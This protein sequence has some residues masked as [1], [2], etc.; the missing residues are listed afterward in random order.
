[1]RRLLLLSALALAGCPNIPSPTRSEV[2]SLEVAIEGLYTSANGVRTPLPVVASCAAQFD[3][4]QAAV[5]L[6]VRG[7]ETCRYLI[8]RGAIEV[9]YAG[10][11]V[12]AQR[13]LVASF[14]GPV[15]VRVIPGD[16]ADP[17]GWTTAVAGQAHA[18]GVRSD[19]TLWTWGQNDS[20]QLGD[21]TNTPQPTPLPVAP[22][23]RWQRVSAGSTFTAG[24]RS[25]GTLWAFGSLNGQLSDDASWSQLSAGA[26]HLLALKADGSL[27]SIGQNE[28]GQLGD[29]TSTTRTTLAR[30]GAES[31]TAVAAGARHSLAVRA[32]GTLWAF[33]ANDQGQLGAMVANA[34]SPVQVDQVTTWR[35][36]AAG[37]GHSLG[38]R[39]DG[40]LWAWGRNDKAQLGLGTAN[41]VGAPTRVGALVD[42]ESV[43][44]GVTHSLG[45]RRPGILYTW[46][47]NAEGEL[48][49]GTVT[50]RTTPQPVGLAT[51][52]ALATAGDTF[53]VGVRDDG[54]INAWG[55]N[56]SGQLGVLLPSL[57]DGG[58]DPFRRSPTRVQ[59][60]GYE[61]RWRQAVNGE[62][63]GV[64]RVQHQY[65]QARLWLENAPPRELFDG[66][67]TVAP[68][69]LPPADSVYTFA[70][71]SSP[72]VWFE[73]QTLQTLNV[74]DTF[75][76]RSS[77]FV[78]EFVRIGTPP[79]AGEVLRQTCLDDPERNG[80]PM[81]MVVTGVESTGFYVTDIT[82]CRLKEVQQIGSLRV[83]TPEPK[84]PCRVALP[85]GGVA[86][87]E[88]VPGARDG[89]CSISRA[90]CTA[91]A[92]C[93]SYSPGTF[94]SL[95]IFNFSF[96][97]GLN[98]GDLL[99]SLSG[100]VQEFTSTTQLT[101]PAWTI[102]ERVRLLPPAQWNKWL[103]LVPPVELN[104]RICG[105]DNVFSPFVT[106]ALCGMSSTNLK[107]ESLE[108]TLV[109][110]RGVKFPDRF[111]NCDFDASGG[112]PFY[113]NR[114]DT[115]PMGTT[116]RSW[117]NC[118][119]DTP[120]APEPENE[121][122]ERTC[123]Q[124]CT[125][126]RGQDGEQ[127]CSETSTFIGF[128][129]YAVE[130]A[131]PGP[132]WA[133]LD[134]SNPARIASTPVTVGMADGGVVVTNSRIGGLLVPVEAGFEA[135]TYAVAVCDVPVRWRLGDAS[136]AADD[137]DPLLDARTVLK[138]RL[139][140]GKDSIS[141]RPT[142]ASGRCYAAINPRARL[143][144]HTTDAIPQLN[145][146]CR[147][148]DPDPAAAERC[149]N[150]RGATY[151]IVGHLKQVQPARPRWIVIPR[152]PDDICC[153]PGPGLECPRPL[154]S[155][156]GT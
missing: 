79:E 4:G 81:A 146:N 122:L 2:A 9:D 39:A 149:R 144:V 116:I 103:N 21:G 37:E 98:Q 66:G 55:R 73:E 7:K 33:G 100:A 99:F 139:P 22:A 154:S 12:D 54:S 155:C 42:W 106:D 156:R 118:D 85:D 120:P 125:L 23:D 78:G 108:G 65:G 52:W 10:R 3:G 110:V 135:G 82:A 26:G 57:R 36:V 64:V 140:A 136:T 13:N 109:K 59:T 28:A 121:R 152:D 94:A 41:A 83:R 14:N 107:L 61:N 117:G 143:N 93:S 112:V 119:F 90:A 105:L 45:I 56:T 145:P 92:Q 6:Q 130:M 75:D 24:I 148:D 84:E 141:L 8:P 91:R 70:T 102:A 31:W 76:N 43:S 20:S 74:P 126:G 97:E 35:V 32:D 67:S 128:G 53:S 11:A 51:D 104:Y 30:V 29:G 80:Q 124:D 133:N 47:S 147:L 138:F 95:F 38:I 40:S 62:V 132:A 17:V 77:P 48:G 113:C 1:M 86:D 69:R 114:T 123:T 88:D 25:D 142:A 60:A 34:L 131:P 71:G 5:P 18:A 44:A 137:S 129:Q 49:D 101:F 50:Q 96:P 89:R 151:D 15:S 46:G 27:W 150:T 16:F 127:V 134:D 115:D 111:V 153:Y 58:V 87:I 19:G 68:D 63:R 72:I